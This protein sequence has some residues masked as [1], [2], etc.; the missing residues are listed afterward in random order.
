MFLSFF[1]RPAIHARCAMKESPLEK[2]EGSFGAVLVTESIDPLSIDHFHL[3]GGEL[4]ITSLGTKDKRP[5]AICRCLAR[6]PLALQVLLQ[7]V[8][9]G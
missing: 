8:D 9:A 7:V 6:L 4:F 3:S 2:R 1:K 5:A